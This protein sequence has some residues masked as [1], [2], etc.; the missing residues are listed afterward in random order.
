M[1][2]TDLKTT[3][4]FAFI[5]LQINEEAKDSNQCKLR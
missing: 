4:L 3:L 2:N 1:P 5:G